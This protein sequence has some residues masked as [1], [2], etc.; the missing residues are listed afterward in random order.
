MQDVLDRYGQGKLQPTKDDPIFARYLQWC[1]FSEVTS[2]YPPSVM[3]DHRR[4]F[5]TKLDDVVAEMKSR[6]ISAV[7]AID[8]IVAD[9]LYILGNLMIAAVL[10]IVYAMGGYRRIV[11]KE[12]P[13]HVR[14]LFNRVS[15]LASY[16]RTVA[17]GTETGERLKAKSVRGRNGKSYWIQLNSPRRVRTRLA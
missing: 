3:V 15:D 5:N 9:R 8:G 2:A 6:A 14:G 13:G 11:S 4:E 1:W 10:S 16:E 12:V 17:A 7:H